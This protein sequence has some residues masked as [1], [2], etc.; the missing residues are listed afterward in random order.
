MEM[1]FIRCFSLQFLVLLAMLSLKSTKGNDIVKSLCQGR[2]G[3]VYAFPPNCSQ[4]IS[5]QRS[6]HEGKAERKSQLKDCAAHMHFHPTYKVCVWEKIYPC[7]II[8][9]PLPVK[10]SPAVTYCR[11][12]PS[13]VYGDPDRCEFYIICTLQGAYHIRCPQDFFFD[14]TLNKCKRGSCSD[15]SDTTLNKCKRGPCSDDSDDMLSI[16]LQNSLKNK[17]KLP[18]RL[19]PT[20]A[21]VQISYTKT[22]KTSTLSCEGRT[23]GKYR[24]PGACSYYLSCTVLG[25]ATVSSCDKH[26]NFHPVLRKCVWTYLYGCDETDFCEKKGSGKYANVDNCYGYYHCV[27]GMTFPQQCAPGLRFDGYKCVD[28]SRYVCPTPLRIT[29]VPS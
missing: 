17:N 9:V 19:Y 20:H 15:D 2:N 28:A 11:G 23:P 10:P 1:W 24:I 12:R 4:Y 18:P 27:E 7:S 8:G 22:S 5:C 26:R 14:T 6:P 13:G 25:G 16:S 29:V 3:G 21:T